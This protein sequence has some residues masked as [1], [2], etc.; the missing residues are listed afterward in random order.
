MLDILSI[1]IAM[2]LAPEVRNNSIEV[3]FPRTKFAVPTF[4]GQHHKHADLR[5][6][7]VEYWWA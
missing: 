2:A 6:F 5:I 7:V 4:S 3:P 1:G